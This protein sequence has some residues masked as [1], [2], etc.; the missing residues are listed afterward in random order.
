MKITA[1][2]L[3]AMTR[4]MTIEQAAA[5]WKILVDLKLV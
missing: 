4:D 5:L 1:E 3:S 2:Q